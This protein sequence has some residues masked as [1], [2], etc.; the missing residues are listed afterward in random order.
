MEATSA[1]RRPGA[2]AIVLLAAVALWLVTYAWFW[3]P[4]WIARQ[5]GQQILYLFALI[6]QAIV[7][8]LCAMSVSAVA[9]RIQRA[10]PGRCP[11]PQRASTTYEDYVVASSS[12]SPASVP[13]R[14]E[15]LRCSGSDV[16]V[17]PD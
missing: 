16:D 1:R 6:A 5:Q 10:L 4:F 14:T 17:Q 3:G 8:I 11:L 7:L 9:R 2:P 15:Q 13:Q 12:G